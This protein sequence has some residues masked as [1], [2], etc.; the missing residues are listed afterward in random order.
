M[1]NFT[2]GT[3]FTDGVTNDV[4]A[5]KLNAL[6][7]DAVPTSS[8]SL[9][10]TTGTIGLFSSGT[11]TAATPAIQPTGDTNTGI[12]FPAADTIA[13]SDGGTESMRIDSS[14]NVG[15]GTASPSSP[16]H[17][18][19]SG[20]TA[21]KINGGSSAN[22]GSYAVF[23]KG[24]ADRLYVGVASAVLGSGSTSNDSIVWTESTN[25]TLFYNNGTER[26]RIDSSGNV[27]IGGTPS[28]LLHIQ[29]TSP[30]L[31][32]QAAS[33][34]SGA[35][36]FYRTASVNSGQIAS[37]STNALVF[38]TNGVGNSGLA[39]RLRIDS[40]GNVGI[41]TASPAAKL[42]I[43]KTI[44]QTDIDAADQI[45]NLVNTATDTSGNLSGIRFRQENGTN[46][47][48]SFIG[49]SS[50][51]NS[52][53][54]ASL[55]IAAP[56]TS[57]NS[58]ERL[59]IDSIGNLLVG[60]TSANAATVGAHINTNGK[61]LFTSDADAPL[62]LNRL[63]DDGVLVELQQASALEG[64]ISVSGNTVSY[65]PF[66]G[67]HWSQLEDGSRPEIL[68]GTVLESINQLCQWPDGGNERFAKC[69]ISDT[70]ASKK[71]YGV[72][73]DWDNSWDQTND[74]YVTAVGLFVCRIN[75]SVTVQ[76]GDL[77]ESN[78]DGTARVQAD[79]VIRSSTIGK[80]T[81]SIKTHEHPDGSYCV[82]TVLYCG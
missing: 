43:V 47:A 54:R 7:A 37:E 40:S 39:E 17:V 35:L 50:T 70:V 57:G 56:N 31:R 61:G 6:V 74:L 65:N 12:F 2:A 14:G 45:I 20:A 29:S 55:I 22:Q 78:G 25:N 67:S 36:D 68:R 23:Q 60:K 3:S 28:T 48:N 58:T 13:F 77:L 11:G 75:A 66:A 10:S 1:P 19:G 64:T 24:S 41:G 15:I 49:L 63:T 4:T 27:G 72:F 30:S 80:V 26:V 18:S 5:A 16:L 71:V 82:P 38:S 69:K 52:A 59:R 76:I 8:L 32:I 53:T 62:Y 21:V 73:L 9:N 33:G 46:T 51:G 42:H 79:D 81:S 44:S 34:N